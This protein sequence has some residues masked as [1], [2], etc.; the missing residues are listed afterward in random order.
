MSDYNIDIK[1]NVGLRISVYL[2]E[3]QRLK[4]VSCTSVF[5]IGQTKTVDIVP[6]SLLDVQDPNQMT[7][8]YT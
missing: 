1:K 5:H 3:N 7:G 6:Q 2:K 8:K 4:R